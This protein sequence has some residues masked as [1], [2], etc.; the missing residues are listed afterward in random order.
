MQEP[1][2]WYSRGYL[3]H[4]DSPGSLQFITFRLSDACPKEI[5][6]RIESETKNLPLGRQKTEQTKK[7]MEWLDQ[8]AG[9]CLLRQPNIA[10]I[11][12]DC[13]LYYD[14]VQY[15][16]LSWVVMPNH[17]HVLAEI[18]GGNALESIVHGW[19]SASAHHINSA[20]DRK[21]S[22]WFRE[23][24]DRFIRDG[25]HYQRVVSYIEANPVRA[26]LCSTPREWRWSSA[27][28]NG[29]QAK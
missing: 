15:R 22:I 26:K 8:G 12:E 20:L 29:T 17:V 3:P 4:F 5:Q 13:L 18:L 24:Y 9:S 27:Q 6:F 16:L 23:Y 14:G 11:V 1:K 28:R 2:E 19:K 7:L 21:G 25:E 10:T